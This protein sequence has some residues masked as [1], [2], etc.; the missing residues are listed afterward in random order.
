MLYAVFFKLLFSSAGVAYLNGCSRLSWI[1][2]LPV[3]FLKSAVDFLISAVDI[4]FCASV[5]LSYFCSR[6][7]YFCSRL[8][9]WHSIISY[10]CSLLP[11]TRSCSAGFNCSHWCSCAHTHTVF[12]TCVSYA[13]HMLLWIWF[14]YICTFDDQQNNKRCKSALCVL[15]AVCRSICKQMTF[16]HFLQL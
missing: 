13:F 15:W 14:W 1:H 5:P 9:W 7:S 3:D 10:S 6:L 8:S 11:Q 2:I 12:M 16:N 4:L